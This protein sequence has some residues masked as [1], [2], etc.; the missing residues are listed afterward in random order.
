MAE[1]AEILANPSGA[2]NPYGP[3]NTANSPIIALGEGW[4][5]HMGHFLADQRYGVL[6]SCQ[7]EQKGGFSYCPGGGAHPHIDVLE[8]FVPSLI[9]DPFRWIP[10]GLMEDLIDNGTEPSQ[11][12]VNDQVSGFT[13][14]QIFS[15]LQSDITTVTAYRAR[16]IQQNTGNQTSQV[17]T[18]FAS[19]NY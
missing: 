9:S 19:Y 10:K 11:T 2:L 13:I 14:S 17:T 12:L 7:F 3:G 8:N 5:Y 4:A 18:L 1:L 6:G 15:A 16:F